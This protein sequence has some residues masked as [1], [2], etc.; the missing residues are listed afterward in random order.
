MREN[1]KLTQIELGEKLKVSE[2][3]IQEWEKN[4]VKKIEDAIKIAEFFNIP[5]Q[6]FLQINE[7]FQYISAEDYTKIRKLQKAIEEIMRK[8]DK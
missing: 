4:G 3:T 1:I 7:N 8:Y 6:E 5:I 2:R